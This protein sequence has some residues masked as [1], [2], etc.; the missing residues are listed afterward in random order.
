MY[1]SATTRSEK[2]NRRNF[3]VWKSHG[4]RVRV[5]IA[6]PHAVFS[7]VRFCSYTVRRIQCDRPN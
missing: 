3:R 7:A 5:T 6:I 4:H 2:P 1:R